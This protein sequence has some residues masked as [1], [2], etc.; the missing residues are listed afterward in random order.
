MACWSFPLN[1]TERTCDGIIRWRQKGK[2]IRLEWQAKDIGGFENGRYSSVGF[3]EDRFMGDDTV[4]ECVFTADGRGSVHVSFNGGSYNNQLPHATAKLLKKSEAILKERRMICSTEIQLEARKNL[5]NHEKR[6]VYDLNSKAFVLQYAKGL[7][8]GTT[9]EKEI[10]A[11]EEGELYPWTT[12]RKYRL[13][14]DCP[15][16]FVVVTD[17]TQ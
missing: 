14:E 6:K 9:G 1:C 5:E 7:A 12:T 16:K 3:S 15:D 8:D 11:V 17:M 13:C 2:I 4:L 10:H